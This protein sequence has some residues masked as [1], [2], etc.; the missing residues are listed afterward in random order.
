MDHHMWV[1]TR[2]GAWALFSPVERLAPPDTYAASLLFPRAR[3]TYAW[4]IA[5]FVLSFRRANARHP[6]VDLGASEQLLS[7]IR[8]LLQPEHPYRPPPS[9]GSWLFHYE[10][11][12]DEFPRCVDVINDSGFGDP[13]KTTRASLVSRFFASRFVVAHLPPDWQQQRMAFVPPLLSIDAAGAAKRAQP[14]KRH[15]SAQ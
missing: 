10:P 3:H 9:H 6:F 12:P 8:G 4:M 5:S 2:R 14:N 13:A 7:T 1:D 15:A 11:R